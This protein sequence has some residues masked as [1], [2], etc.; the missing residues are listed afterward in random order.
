MSS[1]PMSARRCGP[2]ALL[3]V[4]SGLPA[5]RCMPFISQD[6][7]NRYRGT[8][9]A[10]RS[11]ARVRPLSLLGGG[12]PSAEAQCGH[13]ASQ[14][15]LQVFALELWF[16]TERVDHPGGLQSARCCPG[17]S[18]GASHHYIPPLL[19][20]MTQ[21]A[22][23][24]SD[25]RTMSGLDGRRY[26]FR[27]LRMAVQLQSLM[28]SSG[29]TGTQAIAV[30]IP[31][32][33][34]THRR[35]RT[36][37]ATSMDHMMWG[38]ASGPG[39]QSLPRPTFRSNVVVTGLNVAPPSPRRPT[40]KAFLSLEPSSVSQPGPGRVLVS[41]AHPAPTRATL[42]ISLIRRSARS[43]GVKRSC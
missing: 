16:H 24:L 14:T 9:E 18:A 8:V 30:S 4:E 34:R 42:L 6:M 21:E 11:R 39:A 31:H 10:H 15:G 13:P 12:P 26:T 27:A 40:L 2:A 35:E 1:T 20:C 38:W 37:R 29:C 43:F 41:A 36:W 32:S 22:E 28:V 7:G 33:G 5:W 23:A 3:L 19:K 25:G 17:G